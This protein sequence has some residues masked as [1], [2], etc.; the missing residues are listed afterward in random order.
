MDRVTGGLVGR[1]FRVEG[2]VQGVGFRWFARENATRLGV[3][4]WVANHS[5]DSVRGEV[6]GT[7][8][9]VES[10]L[11]AIRR[12]PTLGRVERFETSEIAAQTLTGFEILK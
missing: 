10:F 6:F 3:N 7:A 4:G 1:A 12:G 2:V 11:A 5:D 8:E 9:G